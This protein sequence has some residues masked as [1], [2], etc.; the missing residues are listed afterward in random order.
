MYPS[1]WKPS[2]QVVVPVSLSCS[3]LWQLHCWWASFPGSPK[4]WKHHFQSAEETLNE[5]WTVENYQAVA[6][7]P[8]NESSMHVV[9]LGSAVNIEAPYHVA[10]LER[11][12]FLTFLPLPS[13]F[14]P[15]FLLFLHVFVSTVHERIHNCDFT[16]HNKCG[17]DGKQCGTTRRTHSV[18]TGFN[19]G[20][21]VFQRGKGRDSSKMMM[22]SSWMVSPVS[23]NEKLE[24][25]ILCIVRNGP[26]QAW[27]IPDI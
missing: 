5:L 6:V 2:L 8:L 13:P 18:M 7:M 20:S 19:S 24:V 11:P 10:I 12:F 3:A 27:L 25:A 1:L 21:V 15:Y 4:E 17:C 14:P 26:H 22:C 23:V 16:L 9:T